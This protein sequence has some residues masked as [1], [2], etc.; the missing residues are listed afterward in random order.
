VWRSVPPSCYLCL[1]AT[2]WKLACAC[3]LVCVHDCGCMVSCCM[4]VGVL[5]DWFAVVLM[6]NEEARKGTLLETVVVAVA[7]AETA[8]PTLAV[9]LAC[10]DN[11]LHGCYWC[12]AVDCW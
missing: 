3:G 12:G 7:R 10:S 5:G 4:V 2:R 1:R 9:V 6:Q 8:R 11:W